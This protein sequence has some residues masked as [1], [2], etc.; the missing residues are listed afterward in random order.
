MNHSF[1]H[2]FLHLDVQRC[3]SNTEEIGGKLLVSEKH[4][5]IRSFSSAPL[6]RIKLT[7]EEDDGSLS[8]SLCKCYKGQSV[9]II[10]HELRRWYDK[11]ASTF[12]SR[13]A[14]ALFNS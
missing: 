11:V 6:L 3:P 12:L 7:G 9:R 13:F 2:V 4:R 1:Y 5:M 14:L 8:N 10:A